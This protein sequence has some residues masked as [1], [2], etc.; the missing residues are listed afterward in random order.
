MWDEWLFCQRIQRT[1]K[2]KAGFQQNSIVQYIL[3]VY[4]VH[5]SLYLLIPYPYIARFG[6]A[7]LSEAYSLYN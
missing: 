1:L 3:V 6:S 5:Y 2:Q 7:F 4:F